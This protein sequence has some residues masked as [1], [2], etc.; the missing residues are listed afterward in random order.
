M[1]GLRRLLLMDD[2]TEE[3]V[4]AELRTQFREVVSGLDAGEAAQ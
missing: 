3:E 2:A 4:K 1:K